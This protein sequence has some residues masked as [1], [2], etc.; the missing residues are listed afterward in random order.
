MCCL[1]INQR[2]GEAPCPA[3]HTHRLIFTFL[4]GLDESN[5]SNPSISNF[6]ILTVLGETWSKAVVRLRKGGLSADGSTCECK[7]G[8]NNLD[9]K[10]IDNLDLRNELCC[11][12]VYATRQYN[13][14]KQIKYGTSQLDNLMYHVV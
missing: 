10:K 12:R 13:I 4:G 11:V 5:A 14:N 9:Q 3:A 6:Q 1:E 8:S 7:T 2:E